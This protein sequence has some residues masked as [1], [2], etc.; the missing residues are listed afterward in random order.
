MKG[1]YE[2]VDS[3]HQ[4][5][6]DYYGYIYLIIDHLTKL[7][8]VGQKKG[9]I[10]KSKK[11]FG[12]GTIISN[13]QNSR[14]TIHLQKI[15]LGVCYSQEELNEAETECIYFFR[16]YGSDGKNYDMIYGY[17]LTKEGATSSGYICLEE[18]K[19]KIKNSL[20][21]YNPSKEEKE[22]ISRKLSLA[23]KGEKNGMFGKNHTLE[24]CLIIGI[25]NS[26]PNL[27]LKGREKTEEH[28]LHLQQSL[29]QNE[30]H[31]G[32]KNG[33]YID[34]NIEEIFKLRKQGFSIL[35]ISIKLNVAT[36]VIS[37]RL[38]NPEKF[39]KSDL[40]NSFITPYKRTGSIGKNNGK[41]K[42]ID[43]DKILELY[44]KGVSIKD[45]TKEFNISRN[46]IIRRLK[47]PDKFR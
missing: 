6:V 29:L 41:C 7:K 46:I 42:Q 14:G 34:V 32:I 40:D 21:N 9:K 19:I 15:I 45:L 43:V 11:Y 20:L 18:T 22:E 39:I 4:E 27:K 47:N 5:Y 38:K 30:S 2:F 23:C 31:S 1:K 10:Y 24:T 16:T 26:G 3:M 28:K 36:H 35:E 33:R 44:N 8:Y 37:R 25:K 17:N 13:I 12:S